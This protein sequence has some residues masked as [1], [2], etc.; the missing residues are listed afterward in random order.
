M[1][2]SASTSST[3]RAALTVTSPLTQ[4]AP[5][6]SSPARPAPAA[7]ASWT[8]QQTEVVDTIRAINTAVA[9]AKPDAFSAVTADSFIAVGASGD[10]VTKADRMKAIGAAKP[11]PGTFVPPAFVH[12]YD[13]VATAGWTNSGGGITVKALA[14]QNGRWV[15]LLNHNA[16]AP[17]R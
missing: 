3:W 13:D 14:K 6:A 7:P 5:A 15:Q 10:V 16:P 11:S 2:G 1:T 17:A 4:A 8:P 12:V 9:G